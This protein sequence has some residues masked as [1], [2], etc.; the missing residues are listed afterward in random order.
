VIKP[1]RLEDNMPYTPDPTDG[2]APLDA[3]EARTAAAEFRALKAW[4][5]A[6]VFNKVTGATV[7]GPSVFNDTV[8]FNDFVDFIAAVQFGALT[9]YLGHEIGFRKIVQRSATGSTFIIDDRGQCV[10]MAGDMTVPSGVFAA[11]DVIT[12]LG[13]SA[14]PRLI[15]Q[16]AGLTMR[17]T[18]TA[19]TG[20]RILPAYGL[21]TIYFSGAASAYISGPGMT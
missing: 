10:L 6:N 9:N 13:N 17:L 20:N 14:S 7:A 12:V 16:G 5:Q 8:D 3:T 21:C 19:L 1:K 2:A 4:I 15:N 18:G 11:G